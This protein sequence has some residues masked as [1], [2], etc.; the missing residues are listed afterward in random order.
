[1]SIL[2]LACF[3]ACASNVPAGNTDNNTD[4]DIKTPEVTEGDTGTVEPTDVNV[5]VLTGPTGIGAVQMWD[6]AEKE[7]YAYRYHFTAVATPTEVVSRI[8]KGEADIAAVATNLAAKMYQA[9]EKGVKVLAV[10]TLGVLN[11]LTNK[12]LS[13]E[14]WDDLRGKDVYS[15]GQGAN[16]EYIVKYLMRKNG[17]DPDSDLTLHFVAEGS[18][19]VTVWANDPQA[20]LVAPQ[21]VATS[22]LSKYEGSSLDMDLT[23]E[24]EKVSPDSAL[25]MGCIIVRTAFLDEHPDAVAQFLKDYESSVA[26][27]NEDPVT[28]GELCAKYGIVAAAPVATKAIP[29]CHITYVAGDEMRSG[30]EG[31]LKVMLDADASSIGGKLPDDDFYYHAPGSR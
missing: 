18:E 6:R 19:L 25:M 14:T 11:I 30:L 7:E 28:T 8:S 10:N 20:V 15:A 26:L 9:T 31:Y 27:A 13:V 21:P 1:M 17:I 2:V 5:F 24:W 23:E 16:P 29:Y 4:T 3:T 12:D 22:I